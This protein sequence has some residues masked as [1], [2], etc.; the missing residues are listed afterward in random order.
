MAS[1]ETERVVTRIFNAFCNR[2]R[3]FWAVGWSE[4]LTLSIR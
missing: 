2:V 1:Q 4:I 3:S